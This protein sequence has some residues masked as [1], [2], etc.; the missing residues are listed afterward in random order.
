MIHTDRLQLSGMV[1]DIIKS[2]S[3]QVVKHNADTGTDSGRE[4]S[5]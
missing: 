4:A 1:Q 5:R 2:S 3:G